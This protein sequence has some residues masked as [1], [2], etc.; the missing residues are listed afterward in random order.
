MKLHEWNIEDIIWYFGHER[1]RSPQSK[2]SLTFI[3]RKQPPKRSKGIPYFGYTIGGND[4]NSRNHWV[5]A[6]IRAEYSNGL[7]PPLMNLP[8]S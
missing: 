8:N 4:V 5:R 2:W 6:M 3:L 7:L 1:R